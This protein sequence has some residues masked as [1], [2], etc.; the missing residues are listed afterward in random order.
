MD[1]DERAEMRRRNSFSSRPTNLKQ[2][3]NILDRVQFLDAVW[4]NP[5]RPQAIDSLTA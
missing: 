3:L 5:G 2:S 1:L 4:V